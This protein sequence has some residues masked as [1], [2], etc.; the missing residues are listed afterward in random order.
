MSAEKAYSR[1]YLDTSV[2]VAAIKGPETED[3]ERV[4]TSAQV[5]SEAE[6]GRLHIIASTFLLVEV[7]RDRGEA[8]PLDPAKE[9][10]A[11][12]FFQRQFISWVE[13]DVTGGRDARIV[14][15]RFNIKLADAILV[16]SSEFS[17]RS[18]STSSA[19]P[20]LHLLACPA[21]AV[22]DDRA[23]SALYP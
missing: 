2:Y 4:K 8:A 16:L 5:L 15:R 9:T 21:R 12:K 6:A 7:I 18:P 20:I 19:G 17:A 13:L 3:P 11:E 1:P 14:A 23:L 10:L 22:V